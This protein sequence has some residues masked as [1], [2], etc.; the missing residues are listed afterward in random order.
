MFRHVSGLIVAAARTRSVRVTVYITG[1]IEA[2][3][4]P[5][6]FIYN[7]PCHLQGLP[8]VGSN[9]DDEELL[10]PV[11]RSR[12]LHGRIDIKYIIPT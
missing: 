6:Q 1:Q 3:G 9:T 12:K 10:I 4:I 5:V 8:V 7:L 2:A 11:P